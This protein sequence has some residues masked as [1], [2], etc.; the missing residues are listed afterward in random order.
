M[1]CTIKR[2]WS[3]AEAAL[4]D[5]N[6]EA[7]LRAAATMNQFDTMQK[8]GKD[9]ADATMKAFGVMSRNAQTIAVE[10]TDYAKRSFEQGT[11]ALERLLSAKTVESALQVQTE[12]VRQAYEGFVAQSTKMG[13]L[14]AGLAQE[15]MAP[16]QGMNPARRA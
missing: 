2:A 4:P 12:Y 15:V 6:Q 11:A 5:P 14:Y 7:V 9:G 1:R 3:G 10:A 13:Q 16:F 8:F